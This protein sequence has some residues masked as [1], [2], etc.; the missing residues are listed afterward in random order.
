MDRWSYEQLLWHIEQAIFLS[1][2]S[3]YK[4][5]CKRYHLNTYS[6]DMPKKI[7]KELANEKAVLECAEQFGLVGDPT[8]MKICWLLCKHPELSVR[9][10]ADMLTVSISV[11][12]HSLKK[13][14]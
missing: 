8:R 7:K 4:N 3:F 14:R 1:T 2:L 13:L 5:P 10:I 6:N 9:E 12:S 11:V